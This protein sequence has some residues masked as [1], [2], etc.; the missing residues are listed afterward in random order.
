MLFVPMET[1]INALRF[2]Y[3]TFWQYHNCVIMHAI[4]LLRIFIL[5][6]K[7]VSSED[8]ET[9]QVITRVLE[10]LLCLFVNRMWNGLR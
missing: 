5:K 3:L 10:W 4:K 1:G 8:F 7:Y 2:T 9:L 6:M